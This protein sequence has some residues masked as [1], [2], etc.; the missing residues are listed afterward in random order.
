MTT[1]TDLTRYLMTW[2]TSVNFKNQ[3]Y[4]LFLIETFLEL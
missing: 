3:D 2:S 1:K 4:S